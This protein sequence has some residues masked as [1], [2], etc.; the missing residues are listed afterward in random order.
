MPIEGQPL[1]E[2]QEIVEDCARILQM[3]VPMVYVRQSPEPQAYAIGAKPPHSIVLTNT[4]LDLFRGE[5]EQLRFV[6]GHELGHIKCGHLK[7]KPI[8][9]AIL[10]ALAKLGEKAIGDLGSIPP[11]LALGRFLSWSREA[12]V[13]ADRAGLLCCQDINVAG[14]ALLRLLHGL[15]SDSEWIDKKAKGFDVKRVIAEFEK[16]EDKPFAEFVLKVKQYKATHP[17]I[18][19]RLAALLA[20]DQSGIPARILSRVERPSG[21]RLVDVKTIILRDLTQDDSTIDPYVRLCVRQATAFTTD[22]RIGVRDA[23]WRPDAPPVRCHD[24]EPLVFEIWDSNV[25]IP[26]VRGDRLVGAFVIYP[27]KPKDRY[28]TSVM[29]DV[30]ERSD[31]RHKSVAKVILGFSTEIKD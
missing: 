26:G 1:P 19:Q 23:A 16:W 21:Q 31:A 6:I 29:W 28:A 8:A 13:S 4:L 15:P 20:F 12:E 30:L 9:V 10:N 3:D 2:I 27:E 18:Q 24:G 17:F 22:T 14:Q 11:T 7:K 5:H 25:K